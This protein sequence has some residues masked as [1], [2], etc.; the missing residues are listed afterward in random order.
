VVNPMIA[1]WRC[2]LRA[3]IAAPAPVHPVSGRI[4]NAAVASTVAV[5][6]AG[7][8]VFAGTLAPALAQDEAPPLPETISVED[9]P[10]LFPDLD[11]E[12]AEEALTHYRFGRIAQGDALRDAITDEA[13]DALLEWAAVRSVE[14]RDFERVSGFM[15]NHP[16]WAGRNL[17]R[18]RAEQA[19]IQNGPTPER[20][21]TFFAD[22]EPRTGRGA[23][24]LTQALWGSG[25]REAAEHLA[26]RYWRERGFDENTEA[27]LLLS[28][29]A[30]FTPSDHRLRMENRLFAQ[31]W[32][33]ARRAARFAGEQFEALVDLRQA[34][35]REPARL[36]AAV[37]D[38]P[39]SL[40]NDSSAL[41]AKV[42]KAR[43]DGDV[44]GAAQLIARA[45]RAVSIIA[46]GDAWWVERRIVGRNLLEEGEYALAYEII[47]GHAAQSPAE[48]LDAEFH[49]GWI[50]LRFLDDAE[51]ALGHFIAAAEPAS[52]PVSLSRV[53]YWQARAHQALGD[54]D[55]ARAALEEAATHSTAFYGQL[56]RQE[57][58]GGPI[59]LRPLPEIDETVIAERD[60]RLFT[61]AILLLHALDAEDLAI[62]LLGDLGR[63]SDDAA[64]LR[65][66]GD[67]AQ[68]LGNPRAL[69]ALARSALLRGLPLD[70]HAFPVGAIPE[71][72]QIGP[73][74]E[75]ALV[76]AIARQESAFNADAVSPAGALGLMQFMPATARRVAQRYGVNFD[77]SRLLGDPAFSAKLGAAHLGEL[78]DEWGG[79]AA[80]AFAAYNAGPGHARRW[81]QRFGDPRRADRDIIDWVEQIP[82]PETRSYIQRV[83]E[84]L[85]V[86][87]YRLDQDRP[88]AIEDDLRGARAMR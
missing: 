86:Y 50:A 60:G 53:A 38:L 44:R 63:T 6:L 5:M 41:Y 71:Y 57:L 78:L 30:A 62:A 24:M 37:A 83:M 72:P 1:G 46:D 84:N 73:A 27:Q 87:R 33:A 12:A 52:T 43:L 45:P 58:D 77:E 55:A 79:S 22:E 47:A 64:L 88:L 70:E 23:L 81:I 68:A 35:L 76:H 28:F 69:L 29:A 80:L 42:R 25:A 18:L 19:F 4:R 36:E 2:R 59:S 26:R 66:Y 48:F 11:F 8:L 32:P 14:Q 7:A 67:L 31:D 9:I 10:A 16:D 85:I 21:L 82:F 75:S 54:D 13:A 65:A 17:L 34:L 74:V 49:A 51:T 40:R 61:R 39:S 15:R 3:V 20:V 56:A